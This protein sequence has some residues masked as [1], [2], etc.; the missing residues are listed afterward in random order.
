MDKFTKIILLAVLAA[1]VVGGYMF[2][3]SNRDAAIK[4]Q[5]TK[6]NQSL[7][8]WQSKIEMWTKNLTPGLEKWYVGPG[9]DRDKALSQS[10]QS[11]LWQIFI[12]EP[13]I[14][15]DGHRIG[16]T[17]QGLALIKD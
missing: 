9:P 10:R 8:I 14:I 1:A 5:L 16:E 13:Q 4:K 11:A 12:N 3:K 17:P 15:P 6:F 7:A 2:Y